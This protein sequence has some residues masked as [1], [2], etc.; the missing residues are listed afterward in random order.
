LVTNSEVFDCLPDESVI[1]CILDSS[2]SA[3]SIAVAETDDEYCVHPAP[4]PLW[5]IALSMSIPISVTFWFSIYSLIPSG[6]SGQAML[7]LSLCIGACPV[8]TFIMLSLNRE[9]LKRGK[10]LI[11]RKRERHLELPRAEISIQASQIVAFVRVNGWHTEGGSRIGVRELSV[12]MKNSEGK[13][14]R[15]SIVATSDWELENVQQTLSQFFDVPLKQ[16]SQN[17]VN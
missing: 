8:G 12:L 3:S 5:L 15:H 1:T 11:L 2:N 7:Y 13:I 4:I 6:N 10:F 16:L 14:V 9:T 17:L